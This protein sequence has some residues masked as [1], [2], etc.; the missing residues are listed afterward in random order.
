MTD[1]NDDEMTPPTTEWWANGHLAP[2]EN[3]MDYLPPLRLE[4][5]SV[6]DYEKAAEILTTLAKIDPSAFSDQGLEPDGLASSWAREGETIAECQLRVV[7][8][9]HAAA[10]MLLGDVMLNSIL[11]QIAESMPGD[12]TMPPLHWNY[13]KCLQTMGELAR[14]ALGE[15]MAEQMS[16]RLEAGELDD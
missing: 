5:D 3:P 4:H 15:Y 8:A 2:Y 12:S 13:I 6:Y 14:Q 16:T 1:D 7:S 11:D 9:C 10:G